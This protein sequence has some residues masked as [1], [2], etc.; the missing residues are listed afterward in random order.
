MKKLFWIITAVLSGVYIFIPEFTDIIPIIGWLDEATA[1][2]VLHYALKQLN[3]DIFAFFNKKKKK[4]NKTI[5]I[6]K[7]Q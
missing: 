7:D 5:I 4:D 6:E 2:A 3:I 1:L